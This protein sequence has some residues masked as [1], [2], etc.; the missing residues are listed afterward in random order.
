[1]LLSVP[2]PLINKVTSLLEPGKPPLSETINPVTL[3]ANDL[4]ISLLDVFSISSD[5]IIGFPGETEKDFNDT[6]SLIDEIGFDK[7]FS[8][9]Y[10][11]RPGTIASSMPDDVSPEIKK[12]RLAI[13]QDRLNANTEEISKSM[14]GSLQQVLV[15][16]ASKKGGTLSARTENM[17]TA[18]FAGSND[19]IGKI[20]TVK[21]L[22]G[23]GNSLQASLVDNSEP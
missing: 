22:D 13:I 21:I 15:E 2:C 5:F 10:S 3:P 14:I 1:M 6:V 19:L 17:R 16:G 11:K 18:H 12:Q 20:V 8:F 7:S 23:I 9:I 4:A